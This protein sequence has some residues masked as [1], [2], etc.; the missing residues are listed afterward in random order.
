MSHDR[1]F[2]DGC[3]DH[4]MAINRQDITVTKGNFSVWMEN[5]ERQDAME[6]ARNDQLKRKS[7][8]CGR[9][10]AGRRAGPIRRKR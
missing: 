4:I 5:K 10:P 3:V 1:M 2:L 8:S 7:E 6:A 9:R